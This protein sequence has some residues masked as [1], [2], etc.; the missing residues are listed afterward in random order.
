MAKIYIFGLGFTG[1]TEYAVRRWLC[2]QKKT[3][4]LSGGERNRVSMA[5][6]LLQNANFLILD[7]PT[8]HLD[9]PSKEILLNALKQYQGTIL[10]VSHDQDFVN[11]LASK[12]KRIVIIATDFSDANFF[13][14]GFFSNFS[15]G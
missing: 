4:V 15:N 13:G 9:I 14:M 1:M 7:E 2:R 11:K 10:F 8:N 6:V 3:K 5:S 12:I